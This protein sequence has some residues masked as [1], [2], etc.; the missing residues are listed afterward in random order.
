MTHDPQEDFSIFPPG[1]VPS[2][3]YNLP[4]S[5]GNL[6]SRADSQP[7]VLI[8]SDTTK[9]WFEVTERGRKKV[10][11]QNG[12]GFPIGPTNVLLAEGSCI[13]VIAQQDG[14]LNETLLV[15]VAVR[16]FIP[17]GIPG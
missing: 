10:Y 4:G 6:K 2:M 9:F 14:S 16:C 8:P 3:F 7:S 12:V 13:L 15:R 1:N 5:T 11:D 17:F